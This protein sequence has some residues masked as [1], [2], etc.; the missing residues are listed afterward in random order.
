L[1]A[2]GDADGAPLTL[3]NPDP[4]LGTPIVN[5]GGLS[6]FDNSANF[7][8][9]L[10]PPDTNGDVGPS[11]YVQYV[12]LLVRVWSKS[13]TPIT[14]PFKLGGPANGAGPFAFNR[15]RMLDGD[16]SAGFIY[17]NLNRASHPDAGGMLPSD[18]DGLTP[19]PA[20]RANTFSYF[21]ANEF[22]SALDALRLF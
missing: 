5:F 7:G 17:F 2:P 10:S 6:N 9:Q 21:I 14:G 12:N 4:I 22:G 20:G 3:D 15:A 1:D 16:P 11:H 8:F 19:P 18:F 13:G